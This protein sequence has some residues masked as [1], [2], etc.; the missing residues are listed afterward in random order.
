MT[1]FAAPFNG[2]VDAQAVFHAHGQRF[3]HHHVLAGFQGSDAIIGMR[4]VHRRYIDRI[5][6]FVAEQPVRIAGRI[7][8][9]EFLEQFPS[10]ILVDIAESDHIHTF[11]LADTLGMDFT[12][13]TAT[14]KSGSKDSQRL[15][16][17]F[18]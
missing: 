13:L 5:D 7:V 14:D 4:I 12:V 17:L 11:Q 9:A 10:V 16:L 2:I 6:R 18:G 15:S 1:F 8:A 3:F